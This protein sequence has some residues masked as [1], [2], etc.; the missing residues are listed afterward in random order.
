MDPSSVHFVPAGF[1]ADPAMHAFVREVRTLGYRTAIISNVVDEWLPWWN[2]VTPPL[3]LFDVV[4]H[5]CAV[6]LRKPNPAIYEFTLDALGIAAH[7]ALYLDDFPAMAEAA[8]ALGMVTVHVTDH[9]SAIAEARRHLAA[10]A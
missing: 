7:E 6:G 8:A 10:A 5:S 2:A 9:A 4:V 1:E 3:D